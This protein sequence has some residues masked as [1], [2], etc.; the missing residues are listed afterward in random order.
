MA[1]VIL[2]TGIA[3]IHGRLGNMIYRSY[4]QPDGSFKVFVHEAPRREKGV[5]YRRRTENGPKTDRERTDS[6]PKQ[7]KS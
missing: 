2:P 5:I 7:K 4:K 6:D 1:R 3:A